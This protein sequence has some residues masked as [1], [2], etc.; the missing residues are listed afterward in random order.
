MP[1]EFSMKQEF[2]A[3]FGKCLM[4]ASIDFGSLKGE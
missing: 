4:I 3:R 2:Q 1:A